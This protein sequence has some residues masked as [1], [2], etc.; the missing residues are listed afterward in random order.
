MHNIFEMGFDILQKDAGVLESIQYA[1]EHHGDLSENT[2]AALE[3]YMSKHH[4]GEAHDIE[5]LQHHLTEAEVLTGPHAPI[6][7]F[8]RH[9]QLVKDIEPHHTE[10]VHYRTGSHSES[11]SPYHHYSS[12]LPEDDHHYHQ[13]SR[14]APAHEILKH[15]RARQ[16]EEVHQAIEHDFV[17]KLMDYKQKKTGQEFRLFGHTMV[18]YEQLQVHVKENQCVKLH[19]EHLLH[20]ERTDKWICQSHLDEFWRGDCI[21]MD[22]SIDICDEKAI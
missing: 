18:S 5:A 1:K 14:H 8:L 21:T 4:T 17:D 3:E 10:G 15:E 20:T 11:E 12:H 19:G 7:D 22:P 16:A 6:H 9:A 13:E 2:A